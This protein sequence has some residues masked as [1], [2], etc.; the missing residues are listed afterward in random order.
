MTQDELNVGFLTWIILPSTAHIIVASFINV[1][2]HQQRQQIT[3][4]RQPR[5]LVLFIRK[6]A[7]S[8]GSG[9]I[10]RPGNLVVV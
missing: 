5:S 8:N 4:A 7:G 9:S 6:L 2:W 10:D 1:G 3:R